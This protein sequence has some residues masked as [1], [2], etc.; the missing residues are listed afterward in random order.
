MMDGWIDRQTDRQTDRHENPE[1]RLPN[2]Q[3][4][5]RLRLCILGCRISGVSCHEAPSTGNTPENLKSQL[6]FLIVVGNK[7]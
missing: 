7:P 3:N 6:T 4:Q 2:H 5:D 1:C